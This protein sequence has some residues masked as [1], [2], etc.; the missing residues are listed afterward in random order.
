MKAA[1]G[2][3][4]TLVAATSLQIQKQS[5]MQSLRCSLGCHRRLQ[6]IHMIFHLTGA[7]RE[8]LFA[9]R[10][11]RHD[12]SENISLP[13]PLS[14]SALDRIVCWMVPSTDSTSATA[15]TPASPVTLQ[16]WCQQESHEASVRIVAPHSSTGK[17]RGK[18]S[19]V[20]CFHCTL[21]ACARSSHCVTCDVEGG[22]IQHC[23]TAIAKTHRHGQII[24]F[25]ASKDCSIA[26]LR[27][28]LARSLGS[29]NAGHRVFR[30]LVSSITQP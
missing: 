3:T 25:P 26:G 12:H 15:F 27:K 20:H 2:S 17:Q 11:Q 8:S 1:Q 21:H 22:F 5:M 28:R 24:Y 6:N 23:T 29:T 13:T 10:L 16:A 30:R 19:V 7:A 9:L 14:D 18:V 4:K